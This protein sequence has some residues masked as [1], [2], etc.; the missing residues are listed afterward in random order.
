MDVVLKSL[1]TKL[2]LYIGLLI[3]SFFTKFKSIP[4]DLIL[5]MLSNSSVIFR[6]G[7]NSRGTFKIDV[8]DK[9]E[10]N[11]NKFEEIDSIFCNVLSENKFSLGV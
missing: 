5:G 3:N 11:F 10:S 4:S 9:T 2:S 8:T 7:L 6:G 1:L